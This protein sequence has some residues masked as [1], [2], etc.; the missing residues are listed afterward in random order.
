MKAEINNLSKNVSI[1]NIDNFIQ[2]VLKRAEM[3]LRK[4]KLI[5]NSINFS[6]ALVGKKEMRRLNLEYRKKDAVT[7]VLSFSFSEDGEEKEIQGEIILCPE[8]I[9]ENAREDGV[10]MEKEM[11]KNIIH[12]TLHI[13]GYEHSKEMFELQKQAMKESGKADN[14]EL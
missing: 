3:F 7:D 13:I 5:K 2:D 8:V 1:K 10:K 11:A 14:F 9:F 4:K 12:G 6:I